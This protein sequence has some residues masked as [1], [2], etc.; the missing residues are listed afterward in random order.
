MSPEYKI[1]M[2]LLIHGCGFVIVCIGMLALQWAGDTLCRLCGT[3]TFTGRRKMREYSSWYFAC[4]A[5]DVHF[6]VKGN[7][8]FA[9]VGTAVITFNAEGEV[10]SLPSVQCR[11]TDL[12]KSL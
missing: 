5:G 1:F 10:I 4:P 7:F 6:R 11:Q 12:L 3:M 2:A 9:M 8:C